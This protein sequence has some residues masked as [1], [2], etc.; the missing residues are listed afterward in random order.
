MHG[1]IRAPLVETRRKPDKGGMTQ[2]KRRT[3][4]RIWLGGK[5]VPLVVAALMGQEA[6]RRHVTP[7][8]AGRVKIPDPA[9]THVEIAGN[10]LTVRAAARLASAAAYLG[11]EPSELIAEILEERAQQM[12][13]EDDAKEAEAS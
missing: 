5:R 4:K 7:S 1:D 13:A 3:R 6:D 11:V 8:R 2:H 9:P 12:A 10:R